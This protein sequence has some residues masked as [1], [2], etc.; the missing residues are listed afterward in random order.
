MVAACLARRNRG[1]ACRDPGGYRGAFNT[2]V[3][4]VY[5]K[6]DGVSVEIHLELQGGD[7]S[8]C[9]FTYSADMVSGKRYV[10]EYSLFAKV[11]KEGKIV[12]VHE[13]LDT[14]AATRARE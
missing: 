2:S 4:S 10:N 1:P 13:A 11:D 9:R 6:P 3:W 14:L 8:A 7:L 12:E 5:Y